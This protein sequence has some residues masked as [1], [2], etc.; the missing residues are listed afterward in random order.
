MNH[1]KIEIVNS[2]ITTLNY[3]NENYMMPDFLAASLS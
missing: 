3:L 1:T 2:T